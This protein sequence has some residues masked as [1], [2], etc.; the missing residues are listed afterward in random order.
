VTGAAITQC[1]PLEICRRFGGTF[2][3]NPEGGIVVQA[4]NQGKR[5]WQIENMNFT[6]DVGTYVTA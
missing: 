6:D 4:G 2:S 1:S 5:M 3:I